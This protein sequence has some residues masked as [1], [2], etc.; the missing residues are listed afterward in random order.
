MGQ[1]SLPLR[2][3]ALPHSL[4]HV[5]PPQL[6]ATA[7]DDYLNELDDEVDEKMKW[8]AQN[9]TFKDGVDPQGLLD[10]VGTGKVDDASPPGDHQPRSPFPDNRQP[11]VGRS[12]GDGG[13]DGS[14]RRAKGPTRTGV[15]GPACALEVPTS[16]AG[17]PAAPTLQSAASMPAGRSLWA[18]AAATPPPKAAPGRSLR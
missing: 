8:L 14:P 16:A 4:T 18:A 7:A 6:Q 10:T 17:A 15:R 13:W 12:A 11:G 5:A 9:C 2:L 3:T 1:V